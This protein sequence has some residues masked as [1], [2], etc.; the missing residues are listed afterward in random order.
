MQALTNC[1]GLELSIVSLGFF[2]WERAEEVALRRPLVQQ[3]LHLT[4]V[5]D[6]IARSKR[7]F[8]VWQSARGVCPR[9]TPMRDIR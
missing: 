5:W 8:E 6:S 3:G 1:D 7:P 9:A 4:P 2:I